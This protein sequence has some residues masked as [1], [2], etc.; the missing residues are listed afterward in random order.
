LGAP[1][2]EAYGLTECILPVAMSTLA[3]HRAGSV[4]LPL[5]QN[6]LSFSADNEICLKSHFVSGDFQ[7]GRGVLHTG[8]IGFLD[9]DGFL[10]LKD[11]QARIIKLSTGRK[12]FRSP[13]ENK[14]FFDENIDHFLVFG[15]EMPFLVGLITLQKGF[16]PS[17]DWKERLNRY[18]QKFN[19]SLNSY[20][21]VRDF[22]LVERPLSLEREEL[23]PNLKVKYEMVEKNFAPQLEQAWKISSF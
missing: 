15:N 6:Q 21:Q 17:V 22:V 13:I 10:H 4:G 11:R 7:D 23:T 8:D 19:A 16:F 2:L 20:E 5:K 9:R 12:I 3:S 18:I 1:I 14:F